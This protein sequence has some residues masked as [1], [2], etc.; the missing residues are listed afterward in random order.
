MSW[1]SLWEMSDKE[2]ADIGKLIAE[3]ASS[4]VTAQIIPA[5]VLTES[6]VNALTEN[7]S[8]PGLEQQYAEWVAAGGPEE[9]DN[10]ADELNEGDN[11]NQ[12]R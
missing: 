11:L 3:T 4:L 10:D 5:E 8:F 7:G 9:M 6:T 1:N 2:K 12:D